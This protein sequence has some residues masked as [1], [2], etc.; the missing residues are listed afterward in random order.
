M[1]RPRPASELFIEQWRRPQ[2]LGRVPNLATADA[3]YYSSAET[4]GR[5]EGCEMGGDTEP[6]HPSADG[7]RRRRALSKKA[8][9]WRTGCEG[10]ISVLKRRHGLIAAVIEETKV[11]KRWVGWAGCDTLIN[12]GNALERGR[13]DG[14]ARSPAVAE[15]GQKA[16]PTPVLILGTSGTDFGNAYCD[17]K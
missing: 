11:M 4:S 5:R 1:C 16:P 8:A 15:R 17:G 7:R 6:Q 3:G 10:R 2:I 12:I 9:R 14:G 13:R